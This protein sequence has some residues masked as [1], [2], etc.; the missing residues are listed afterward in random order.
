V[1]SDDALSVLVPIL[2]DVAGWDS[3]SIRLLFESNGMLIQEWD[4]VRTDWLTIS[5]IAPDAGL[6]TRAF[7]GVADA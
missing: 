7:Y 3:A 2:E 5:E 1:L 6:E 4:K